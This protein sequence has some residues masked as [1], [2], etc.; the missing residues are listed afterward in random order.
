MTRVGIM[1]TAIRD[2]HQSLLATRMRTE[3]M[4]PALEAMDEIGYHSIECWGGATFDTAMRFL[5][6]DPWERLRQIKSRLKKTPTQ[7]LLR[8]QNAVGYRHYAD[9]VVYAFCDRARQNGMDIFRVFDALNDTRNLEVPFEA[10]KRAGGH[11]QAALCYTTSPVHTVESFAGIADRMVAMGADSL[12]V[13]DMAGILSPAMAGTLV[14]RLKNDHP[15]MSVQMHCHDTSGYSEMAYLEGAKAGADVIDTALSPLAGGTS[16]PAT[17][18]LVAALREY[19]DLDTGLDMAKL[20]ELAAYFKGVRRKYW[21]FESGLL[22]VDAGVLSH[23]VPGGMISNLVGQLREQGAEA[24]L[25]QV[26]E[27]NARVR[28]DLGY[29]PL[30]TP[31]SQIVG[32]QAVLNV[33]TGKRYGSVTRETKNLARGMYG[34]TTVPIAPE[35]LQAIL[36]DEQPIDHRPADDLPPEMEAAREEAGPLA[37]DVDDVLSYVMFPQPAKE[38]LHWRSEGGGPE[39]ELVAAVAAALAGVGEKKAAAAPVSAPATAATDGGAWRQFGR[40]R[41]MR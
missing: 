24:K 39:R 37:R 36:G 21:K 15:T 32:T 25:G 41:Q 3:D 19:P 29:P 26:L 40:M 33:L 30:V 14:G 18:T 20:E 28:A 4:I 5:K 35:V 7:M 31:S 12:C 2:G 23:Q 17:E 11:V 27:E 34:Q 22:G 16:Q 9:D 1:E 10:V 13:K 38:F 6:E 8:G